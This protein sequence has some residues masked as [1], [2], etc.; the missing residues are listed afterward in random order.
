MNRKEARQLGKQ[1]AIL[2]QDGEVSAAYELL[3]PVLAER[4]KF[5]LLDSIGE[6][7]GIESLNV[8][9]PFLDHIA[10]GKTEGGWVVIASALRGQLEVDLSAVFDLSRTYIIRS[11]IW[12]G[13]DIQGERVPG[14]AL[15]GDFEAALE[16]LKPWRGDTN[17]WV[18]RTVGVAVHFWA[19]RSRGEGPARA[20]C[21]LTFL[22]PMFEEKEIEAVKGVGWGLKTLGRYYPDLLADWLSVQ[23]VQR[24]R[25]YHPVT[26]R[27]ALTY[28]SEDQRIRATGGRIR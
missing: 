12:Y 4:T 7:V 15:T 3:A 8:V 25:A 1:I 18:R 21:L 10:D 9:K 6:K 13:A 14:P 22:E 19:K 27:K 23:V 2:V 17:H 26:L 20:E 24:E 16:G 5:T 11:D 28:L